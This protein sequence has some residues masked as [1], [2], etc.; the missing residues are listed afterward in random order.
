MASPG[1]ALAHAVFKLHGRYALTRFRGG[2]R[3]G[4]SG[5]KPK[6]LLVRTG[7]GRGTGGTRTATG[8][9]DRSAGRPAAPV[10]RVARTAPPRW[11]RRPAVPDALRRGPG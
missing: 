7:P 3:G 4:G 2:G 8:A 10:E 6:W 11:F 9:A 1:F 5:G